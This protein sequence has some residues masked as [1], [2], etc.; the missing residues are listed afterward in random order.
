MVIYSLK[1]ALKGKIADTG[2]TEKGAD[3]ESAPFQGP[4]G[5]P[6]SCGAMADGRTP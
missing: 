2:I 5:S 6:R 4:F 3:A 1:M